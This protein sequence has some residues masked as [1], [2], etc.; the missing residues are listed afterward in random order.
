MI[1]LNFGS[2][3]PIHVHPTLIVVSKLFVLLGLV[4]MRQAKS[5][6]IKESSMC[7]KGTIQYKCL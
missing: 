1:P 2:P 6:N 3:D 4:T 7:T 5:F